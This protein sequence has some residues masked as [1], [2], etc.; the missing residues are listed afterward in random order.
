MK[1]IRLFSSLLLVIF[2]LAA[3]A[4]TGETVLTVGDKAYTQ[5]DLDSLGTESV[6]YTNKDSEVTTYT[7]VLLSSL[8]ED[9]GV[10]ESGANV[11]FTA[12]DG[13]EAETTAEE[14]LACANCIIAF[15]E[16]SLRVVMPDFSSK[17][18]VKDL[19]K[20]SVQ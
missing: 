2:V 20:I 11:I 9:A 13:Y 7:G 10:A 17:L 8:L 12:A 1:K 14:V 18:Q 16:G 6:D 15:D 5:S 19:V 3:C 4:P